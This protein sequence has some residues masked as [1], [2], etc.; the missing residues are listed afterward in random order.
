MLFSVV[1][2]TPA[3][4]D[5]W[6]DALVEAENATPPPKPSGAT[7][8]EVSVKNFVF[9]KTTLEVP[10]DAPFVIDFTNE[11]GASVTHDIDIRQSDGT[12]AVA[13]QEP[14]PGGQ[15]AQYTYDPLPAGTYTFICS[16]HPT[17]PTMRGTLTVQ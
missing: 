15:S 10:A 17:V 8:I 14:I 3:D 13:D 4:F 12:T 1:A 16:V 6:L 2:M 9:D 7:A 5:A 11:D